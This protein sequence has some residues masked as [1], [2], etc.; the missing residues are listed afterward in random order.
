L[1]T[2]AY[3]SRLLSRERGYDRVRYELDADPHPIAASEWPRL[4]ALDEVRADGSGRTVTDVTI[5]YPNLER[6]KRLRFWFVWQGGRLR[7]DEVD[8]EITFAVP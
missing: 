2:D 6:S 7:I 8:G 5:H 4:S 3:L 1:Y